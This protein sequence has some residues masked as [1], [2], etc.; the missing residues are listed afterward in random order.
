V[1][2]VLDV[3][4]SVPALGDGDVNG[5]VQKF[6]RVELLELLPEFVGPGADRGVLR[7][8]IALWPAQNLDADYVLGQAGEAPAHFRLA[9][10]PEECPQLLGARKSPALKG[11]FERRTLLFQAAGR[12]FCHEITD[13]IITLCGKSRPVS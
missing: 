13:L 10:E 8:R 6:H 2:I 7:G 9:N 12:G 5:L 1:G 4:R 11:A 3:L